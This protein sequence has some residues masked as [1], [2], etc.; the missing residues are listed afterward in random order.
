MTGL[1]RTAEKT[2]RELPRGVRI[3]QGRAE[4]EIA[5]FET[6]RRA[7][8]FD[9]SWSHHAAMRQSLRD[10]PLT[11]FQ[12]AEETPRF[13]RPRIIGYSRSIIRDR[14]WSLTEFFV[15]PDHHRRGVGGALLARSLE[16]G[17]NAGADTRLVLASQH[18]SAD[19]L[20][21]RKAG[22]VPRVPMFLL[23]GTLKN[24]RVP[25][26]GT[27]YDTM[28]TEGRTPYADLQAEP[29]LLTPEVRAAFDTLDRQIVGYSRS[30]EHNHW[31]AV[32]GG[33]HGAARIFRR[34]ANGEIVGYAY[35]GPH[36]SGPALALAPHDLPR[37]MAHV[38]ELSRL[39]YRDPAEAFFVTTQ[40]HY[41]AV[42]GTNEIV[43]RW[44][45]DC[46]WQIIFQY[47]FMSSRP[48]GQLD[49][50]VCHNPLYVL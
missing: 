39:R 20:Y 6:M 36:S 21:I 17:A 18:P 1:L 26:V 30:I 46:G 4:D 40:E 33:Y 8:G 31:A 41:C 22:C 5:T 28:Q 7:A 34:A 9:M 3:R 43:L 37:M 15:S 47:L 45:L 48:L 24:L 50:Y 38:A 44:L 10:S 14:V 29:L 11:S 2:G 13:S 32:M 16:D 35:F 25:A 12:V 49:R 23:S 27:I 42:A 19:A